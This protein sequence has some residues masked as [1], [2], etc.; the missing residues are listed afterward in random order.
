M[1]RTGLSQVAASIPC[2]HEC[3]LASHKSQARHHSSRLTP[4]S[5]SC[6]QSRS[7]C[8]LYRET[9]KARQTRLLLVPADYYL[10]LD[11]TLQP[12][13]SGLNQCMKCRMRT[14]VTDPRNSVH[15]MGVGR[16]IHDSNRFTCRTPPTCLP[17]MNIM[18]VRHV[19]KMRRNM[20]L[21][22]FGLCES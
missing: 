8:P 22:L 2:L 11:C 19:G 1:P 14:N 5:Y 7:H 16:D 21:Y 3:S 9:H 13:S 6:H 12:V 20:N 18:R 4:T 17:C 10:G 15:I